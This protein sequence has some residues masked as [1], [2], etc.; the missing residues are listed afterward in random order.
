MQKFLPLALLF[1]V[2]YS[3]AQS[4]WF[5]ANKTLTCGPIKSIISGLMSDKYKETPIWMGKDSA[6]SSHY[7]LFVNE[8][9]G[10]W[11]LVQFSNELGCI[12][13]LG[14]SSKSILP[15]PNV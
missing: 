3:H 8:E 2:S 11:T 15:K 13:G 14:S 1:F 6:E 4:S 5:E 9:T 12:L 7:S 10:A